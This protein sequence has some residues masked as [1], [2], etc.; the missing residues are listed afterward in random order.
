MRGFRC[1]CKRGGL[2]RRRLITRIKKKALET[3][4]SSADQSTFCIYQCLIKLQKV[5][6][7][8]GE[9]REEGGL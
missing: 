6:N 2:Y 1:A 5:M 9:G 8:E 7:F 4:Y 3:S